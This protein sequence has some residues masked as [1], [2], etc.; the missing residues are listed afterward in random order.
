M[1]KRAKVAALP[2]AVRRWNE[3]APEQQLAAVREVCGSKGAALMKRFDGVLAVGA[4]FKKSAN[5]VSQTICLGML[6]KKKRTK[7]IARPVPERVLV[8]L[9]RDGK[10]VRMSIPT[11]VEE[12]GKGKPHAVN[13]AQGVRAFNRNNPNQGVPGAACCVVVDE[14]QP[15]NRFVLGCRHVLALSLLTTGCAAFNA[16]DVADR[17]MTTRLGQLFFPLPMAPNGQPCLDAAIAL[18]DPRIPVE[19]LGPRGIR[20]SVVEPGVRQPQ[21]CFV[22]TPNGPLQAI[23]VKEW[24][25]VPLQYAGCGTV[26]IAGAYQFHAATVGGHSG[27][28]VMSPDGTLFGMHFWGDPGQS[29]AMAIPAFML[30]QPG[31][32]PVS[33]QLA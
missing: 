9:V 29:L 27:S 21:N 22:F 30:F 33:I 20:P 5:A 19:W 18:I 32:F 11:D 23:F 1:A 12:L 16:T 2:A 26:I 6:V 8:S 10:Q 4:G 14:N 24:A 15:A 13:V 3:L 7:S 31:R 17:G 25:N 28:P